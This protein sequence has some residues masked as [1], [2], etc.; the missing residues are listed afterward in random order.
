MSSNM[1]QSIDLRELDLFAFCRKGGS[2]AGE[3]AARD[4]PRILAETAAQAPVSAADEVFAYTATGF[5]RE[6]ASEPGAPAVQRLFLDLAVNGR[7]WLNCQR[8][9]EGYAEP[10]ATSM[11][12][13][14]FATDEAA[15][16]A[17]MDDDELDAIV[18]SKR[19]SLLELIE[20]EVL[21]ALPAAPK[22]AVCPAVHESLVTGADGE[23]EPE[24]APEE[25]EK[26]PSPF[27]ALA[28]L[29]TKH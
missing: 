4:L 12:F 11:R 10:V 5:A 20:D 25:E 28:G 16:S 15:D 26:R 3:V 13:E 24:A 21:L 2:A 17:P 9:L 6:E 19:F 1:T 22:H 7:V 29:K 8:C 27:A 14:V 23:V 18:G